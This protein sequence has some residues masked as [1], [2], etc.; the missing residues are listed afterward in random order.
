MGW[1]SRFFATFLAKKVV[2][3]RG[4]HPAQWFKEQLPSTKRHTHAKEQPRP[5][6]GVVM[7][8]VGATEN[9]SEF[10]ATLAATRGTG[11]LSKRRGLLVSKVTQLKF[12]HESNLPTTYCNQGKG[13][14][15]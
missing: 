10:P 15:A 7:G 9:A 5:E 4:E 11:D 8:D 6:S 14:P 1:C 12:M 13:A 2:A 3:R